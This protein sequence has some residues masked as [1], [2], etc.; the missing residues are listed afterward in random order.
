M[1]WQLPTSLTITG[2]FASK[3]TDK[4]QILVNTGAYYNLASRYDMVIEQHFSAKNKI[5]LYSTVQAHRSTIL[6][7]VLC[8]SDT[9]NNYIKSRLWNYSRIEAASTL[10][11]TEMMNIVALF[12]TTTEN[13]ELYIGCFV[14]VWYLVFQPW[15]TNTDWVWQDVISMYSNRSQISELC[16]IFKAFTSY[17]LL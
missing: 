9:E 8:E 10:Y 12:V 13:L 7:T 6:L 17:H 14:L 15:R 1:Q 4:W 16:H 2:N 11:I 3:E 5:I